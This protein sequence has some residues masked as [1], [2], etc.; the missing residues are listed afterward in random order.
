MF[1]TFKE[2][3]HLN[4]VVINL[5]N[6]Y[7]NV[8]LYLRYDTEEQKKKTTFEVLNNLRCYVI[9]NTSDQN[10]ISKENLTDKDLT[11]QSSI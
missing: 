2:V 3:L 6:D 1:K 11:L 9:L 4:N 7:E 5:I 8:R 10:K